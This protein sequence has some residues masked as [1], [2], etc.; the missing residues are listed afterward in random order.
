MTCLLFWFISSDNASWQKSDS[1]LLWSVGIKHGRGILGGLFSLGW[2][3]SWG[4][5]SLRVLSKEVIG[6]QLNRWVVAL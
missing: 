5:V 4:L 3:G 2:G 6:D 1:L